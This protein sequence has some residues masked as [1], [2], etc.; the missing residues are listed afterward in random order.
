LNFE[1]DPRSAADGTWFQEWMFTDHTPLPSVS[2][3]VLSVDPGISRTG[4]PCGFVVL[5]FSHSAK[6]AVVDEAFELAARA[7]DMRNAVLHLLGVW[8]G[9]THLLWETS[10][11]GPEYANAVLGADFE[12]VTGVRVVPITPQGDKVFRVERD[13]LGRFKTRQVRLGK[14]LPS[15][16]AELMSMPYYGRSPNQ[17]DALS[18]ALGWVSKVRIG[19]PA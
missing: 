7:T 5:S 1:N 2:V 12:Q 4:D 17:A 11:G 19:Q 14:P 18:Q 10:Q 6:C 8:P 16:E 13:V 9:I 15:L 3:R